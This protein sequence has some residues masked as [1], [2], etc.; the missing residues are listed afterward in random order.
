MN[1]ADGT[2]IRNFVP[3][4]RKSDNVIGLYDTVEGVFYTNAGTGSFTKGVD[5]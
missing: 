3:C 1:A 4:Y 5:V 2:P